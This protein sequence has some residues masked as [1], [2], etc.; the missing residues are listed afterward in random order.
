MAAIV[1]NS[2]KND[3]PVYSHILVTDKNGI[4][5]VHSL[6]IHAVPPTSLKGRDYFEGAKGGKTLICMPNISK[7]TG[8][9]VFP[10][11]VPVL[12]E[13]QYTGTMAGFLTMEYV[14]SILNENKIGQN[15]YIMMTG[16]GADGQDGRVIASPVKE[17]LWDKVLTKDANPQIKSLGERMQKGERVNVEI[18]GN[19]SSHRVSIAPVGLYDW[20][21]AVVTPAN[22][23]FNQSKLNQIRYLF[24]GGIVVTIFILTVVS[25]MIANRIVRPINALAVEL[26]A[27]SEEGG[28]LTREIKVE[29]TD[30][31]GDLGHYINQFLG[32][33]RGIVKQVRSTSEHVAASSEELTASA[34]QSAQATN[35]VAIAISKVAN[36]TE[37]QLKA[38]GA[39][40]AIV[41]QMSAGIKQI[42]ANTNEVAGTSAQSAEA[43]QQGSQTL[44]KA[45]D[46]MKQIEGTVNHSAT[47]VI[48]LGERSKEIG[49]IVDTIDG[50][51]GQTNLLALNAAIEAARAGEAG[52]GFAVVA[53]EVR[54]LAEQSQEAA[55]QIGGLISEI[56][57]DTDSAVAAMAKG[58]QEV[59]AGT[60]VVS[61][62]GKTFVEVFEA[63]NQVTG[64]IQEISAA[65][66]QMA[67]GS[68]QIV[69]SVGEIDTISKDIA[70]QSHN[71]SAATEEQAAQMEEITISSQAL[72]KM[73]G[74]LNQVV[75]R[76][77]L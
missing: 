24:Y 47:V 69:A 8:R 15:G 3:A 58:T 21:I 19:G 67:S 72:A 75:S 32:N 13:G 18:D 7:S 2:I 17:E 29:S 46:Q 1:K 55:K 11:A 51:A 70:S 20:S 60:T 39:A 34:E 50:I 9:K 41:E 52:R 27:L 33:I 45:I 48:K 35:Q 73:A 62:V 59:Q 56:Q 5:L 66:E 71:V 77:K 31:I 76:F 14:S 61:D 10:I 57:Q 28:D 44:E 26:R 63:F 30:E 25:L 43:A 16:K 74:E 23:L 65:I 38:V 40:T 53:E 12:K 68:Q 64:Q 54:K 49:Q 4:E 36:G 22:E 6:S 42:A 37:N